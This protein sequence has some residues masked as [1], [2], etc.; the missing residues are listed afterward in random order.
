MAVFL[1]KWPFVAGLGGL[2]SL[3]LEGWESGTGELDVLDCWRLAV[4]KWCVDDIERLSFS[5]IDNLNPWKLEVLF[6]TYRRAYLE[7]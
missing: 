5:I 3:G 1:V 7:R 4:P 2:G 6:K